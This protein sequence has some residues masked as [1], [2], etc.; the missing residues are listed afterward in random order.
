M[1]GVL[2]ASAAVLLWLSVASAHAQT[3]QRVAVKV[4]DI[5]GGNAYLG[6]GTK[7]GL[8]PGA[9]VMFGKVARRIV[10]ASHGFAVVEARG[11]RVGSH[12][13][14]SVRVVAE[15]AAERLPVPRDPAEFHG[16]WPTVE[17]P[18]SRQTPK[19]V[20]LGPPREDRSAT[21]ASLGA[22]GATIVPL[23]GETDAVLRG[24]L[25]AR[26]YAPLSSWPVALAADMSA[27]GW[28]GRYASGVATGDPR[29]W[30]RVRMLTLALGRSAG[31]RGEFGRIPY[32]AANLGPLDGARFEAAR[33]GALKI[34]AFGGVLP[35]PIDGR[36]A[37]GTGRFGLELE[38]DAQDLALRPNFTMVLQGSIFDGQLDERRL[39]VRG[40]LVPGEHRVSAYAEAS[41]FDVD[42]PWFR[43]RAEV[44]AAG[45]EA[46]LRFSAFHIGGR[47]DMRRPERSYWLQNSLPQTWLC[48]SASAYALNVP[49]TGGNDDTR[50]IVQGFSGFGGEQT[51]VDLGGS[52]AGSSQP[53]LGRHALGYATLRFLRIAER[54]DVSLGGSQ[55]GGTLI[56]SSTALRGELGVG[57]WGERLRLNAYYR[58]AYRRYQASVAGLWEQGAGLGLHLAPTP[59]LALD[60]QGDTR[61]GDVDMMMLMLNLLYRLSG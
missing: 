6:S 51:R 19:A 53:E 60:L 4:V 7:H 45:V 36:A 35:D 3:T 12:G 40:Q 25:R 55:E 24:E 2:K 22:S 47:F 44:T 21:A 50:F 8:R 52:W 1:I 17:L 37:W 34:S 27:Q 41:A 29:P 30:W 33:W 31:F 43:P 61:L 46:E 49:C 42:N 28:V 26:L 54:Y 57:L 56:L 13:V 16:M 5:A 58:P 39:Y 23:D 32:A 48:A 9:R 15:Q 38:L 11:L 18:A 10:S 59:R 20:P 14:A